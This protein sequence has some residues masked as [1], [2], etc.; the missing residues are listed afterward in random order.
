MSKGILGSFTV[1]MM[2][3]LVSL[4]VNLG[5]IA[6]AHKKPDRVVEALCIKPGVIIYFILIL[7]KCL[8]YLISGKNLK[9]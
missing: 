5:I 2:L 9:L 8:I 3:G 6:K 7:L 4:S 1:N